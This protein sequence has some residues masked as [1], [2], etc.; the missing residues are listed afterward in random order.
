[1]NS[2][3]GLKDKSA[4]PFFLK[5]A[6]FSGTQSEITVTVYIYINLS[7]MRSVRFKPSFTSQRAKLA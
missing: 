7:S 2:I 3:V 4:R 6:T 5:Q 1:M